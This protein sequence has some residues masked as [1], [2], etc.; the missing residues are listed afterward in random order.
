MM[1]K[2]MKTH[3]L[4]HLVSSKMVLHF[5]CVSYTWEPTQR[6]NG[7]KVKHR[8]TLLDKLRGFSSTMEAGF[9]R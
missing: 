9:D 4:K 7:A 1:T 5:F 3:G 2:V 8:D 6:W